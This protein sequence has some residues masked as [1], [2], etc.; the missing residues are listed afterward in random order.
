MTLRKGE[1][2]VNRKRR[3]QIACVENLPWKGMWTRCKTARNDV[4]QLNKTNGR[5]MDGVVGDGRVDF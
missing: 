4:M 5:R 1:D 3:R 2:I